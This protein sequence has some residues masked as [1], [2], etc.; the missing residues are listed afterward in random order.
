M[1]TKE[2][3]MN[4]MTR[5]KIQG[6]SN[7][8]E[9]TLYNLYWR[10]QG[11]KEYKDWSDYVKIMVDNFHKYTKNNYATNAVFVRANKRLFGFTFDFEGWRIKLSINDTHFGWKAKPLSKCK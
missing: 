2:I 9:E 8:M 6:I 11:E 3:K 1:K 10:W 7:I 4:N 5:D